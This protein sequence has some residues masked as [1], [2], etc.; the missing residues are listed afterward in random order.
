MADF[1][2][3]EGDCL[4]V[5]KTIPDDSIDLIIADPPYNLGKAEWDT[6]DSHEAFL[7]F[8][9]A[10][11]SAALRLL[12]AGG[13]FYVFNTPYNCAHFIPILESLGMEYR[14][15][16][17]WDKRDGQ[18]GA[19]GQFLRR[20]ETILYFTKPGAP[21]TFNTDS[22]RTPYDLTD[23]MRS[24]M[25]TGVYKNGKRWFP[26]PKGKLCG[27][28]WHIT[29]ARHKNKR[30]SKMVVQAHITPKP[31][32]MLERIILASSNIGDTILDPFAGSGTTLLVA[33]DIDRHSIGIEISPKYVQMIKQRYAGR[34]LRL[35]GLA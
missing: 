9:E 16:L 3:L 13:G 5:L 28:V 14:N 8:T 6:F 18:G 23:R 11:M 15:W 30:N 27:D 10:W 29:S 17:T 35:P 25:E 2:L 12:V 1:T 19:S 32:D 24:A 31:H 26:N 4:D 34:P 20:Q 21:H 33:A 22:V 7:G